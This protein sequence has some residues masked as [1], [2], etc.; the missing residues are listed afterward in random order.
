MNYFPLR[1][2]QALAYEYGALDKRSVNGTNLPTSAEQKAGVE[3]WVAFWTRRG[4]VDSYV[5]IS[6][7]S[8][9]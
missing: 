4:L 7:V 9:E 6:L 8:E 5:C 1:R 2:T 3:N